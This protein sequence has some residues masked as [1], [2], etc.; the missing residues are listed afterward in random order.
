[1]EDF[2]DKEYLLV[3]NENFDDYLAF[4]GIGYLHRKLAIN[5]KQIQCL[6][7]N[8]DGTYTFSFKSK[9]ANSEATFTPGV[10][11]VET[12]ADGVKVKALIT[13]EGNKM[14]HTQ[15]EENGRT[16]KHVREFF[17]D[18]L[19]VTTTAEGFDKISTR[20]YELKR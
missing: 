4:I 19:I 20:V 6:V 14:T 5:L 11:F 1:M 8:V 2:L 16:S 3:S 10:D 17:N 9:F 12:K 18:K 13:F 15:I 7:R